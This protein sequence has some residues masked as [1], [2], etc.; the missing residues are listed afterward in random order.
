[1]A[2]QEYNSEKVF[3]CSNCLSLKIRD[4]EHIENS[5]YCEDCGSTDIK[6]SSIE[7]WDRLYLNRFRHHYL[8][9][10]Y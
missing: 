2:K 8:E 5:E 3:Y 6:T 7:E 4:V 1:M 9:N 10:K